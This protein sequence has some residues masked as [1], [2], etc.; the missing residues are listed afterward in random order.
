MVR[1]T[2]LL[3]ALWSFGNQ[4][5]DHKSQNAGESCYCAGIGKPRR[6]IG[7]QQAYNQRCRLSIQYMP[8]AP[9]REGGAPTLLNGS[10]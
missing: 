4:I 5:L 3:R 6:V 2:F 7:L 10:T 1:G 9:G 8:Y